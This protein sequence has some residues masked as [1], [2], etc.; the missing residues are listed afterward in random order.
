MTVICANV[1]NVLIVS[2]LDP[3]AETARKFWDG[4]FSLLAHG[5]SNAK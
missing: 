5:G 2:R 3:L 1:T 4:T